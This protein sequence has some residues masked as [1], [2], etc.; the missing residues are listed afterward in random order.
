MTLWSRIEGWLDDHVPG[1][2]LFPLGWLI[3]LLTLMILL[4]ILPPNRFRKLFHQI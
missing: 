3:A 2:L 1:I 4:A